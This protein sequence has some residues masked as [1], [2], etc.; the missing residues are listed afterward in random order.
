MA[1]LY[2][3]K[4]KYQTSNWNNGIISILNKLSDEDLKEL[5]NIL[6]SLPVDLSS[7]MENVINNLL[8]DINLTAN[9]KRLKR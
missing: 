1:I 9:I 3:L 6:L 4:W 8:N 5:Y 2:N 7:N